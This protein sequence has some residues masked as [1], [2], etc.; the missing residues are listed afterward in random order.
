MRIFFGVLCLLAMCGCVTNQQLGAR[1]GQPTYW[2]SQQGE[3][4]VARY[5]SLSDDSL[6][7]VKVTMPDGRQYTLPEAVSASG[8]RYTDENELVWWEHQ[9]TVYVD[10]RRSG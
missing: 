7:F 6:H 9:G 5:G 4:F 3:R 2:R 1:I 10:V 8:A